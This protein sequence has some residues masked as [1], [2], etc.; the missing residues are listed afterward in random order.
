MGDNQTY[1]VVIFDGSCGFCRSSLN[2]LCKKYDFSSVR[3]IP[4]SDEIAKSWNFPA[5]INIEH[6]KYM[7]Y[8]SNTK[9]FYKGYFAFQQ[10]FKTNKKTR[11]FSYVMRFKFIQLPGRAMY[12]VISKNRKKLSGGSSS[13]AI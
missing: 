12:M 13:C 2:Y 1:P 3:F 9:E 10:L 7:F 8:I 11:A 6:K 5:E 4:Y